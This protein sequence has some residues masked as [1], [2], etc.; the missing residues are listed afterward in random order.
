MG[1]EAKS[2]NVLPRCNILT[3]PPYVHQTRRSLNT[4]VL[5]FMEPLLHRHD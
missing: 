5:I 1:Q 2:I 4:V 3:A